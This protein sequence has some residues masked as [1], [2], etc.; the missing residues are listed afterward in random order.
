MI[1]AIVP[2]R[3]IRPRAYGIGMKI[4]YS[5]KQRNGSSKLDNLGFDFLHTKASKVVTTLIAMQR[6]ISE[7]PS[8]GY[9][10][11]SSWTE[12]NL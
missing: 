10:Y 8:L 1:G 6:C 11:H 12:L 3:V 5:V 9:L 7:S 2:D 4:W